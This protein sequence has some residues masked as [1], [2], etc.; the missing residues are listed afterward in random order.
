MSL[1]LAEDRSG[2]GRAGAGA[3]VLPVHGWFGAS[4][5]TGR[6][7]LSVRYTERLIEAGIEVSDD[8]GGD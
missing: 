1:T 7:Y 6:Q 4:W 2:D 3:M 5:R 8:N